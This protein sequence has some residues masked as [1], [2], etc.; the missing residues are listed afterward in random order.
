MIRN[1]LATLQ[2]MFEYHVKQHPHQ[3]AVVFDNQTITYEQLNQKANQLACYLQTIGVSTETQIALCMDRSIDLFIVILGILKAGAAYVPLDASYPD[4][5]LLLILNE[6]KTSL[7]IT[8]SDYSDKFAH[9]SG[10]ILLTGANAPWL[11]H[12]TSLLPKA[13]L[14]HHLAYV[15]YTSGSTGKPKGV[16]VEHGGVVAYATWFAE[17][18]G[19]KTGDWIDFSSN[20]AFDFAL[21][22]SIIP[23]VL[24]ATV[25]ICDDIIKKDPVQYLEYL[26]ASKVTFIKLTPSYF[27]VLLH[28][29]KLKPMSL[30]SVQ[31][32]ML[33]G[34]TLSPVECQAWLTLYP[35]HILFNE[36]GPTETS[37]AVCLYRIDSI[38][39]KNIGPNMPIG[40]LVPGSEA[41]ILDDKR[42][43]V[44]FGEIGELY[45][46]GRCL[47][48]G[49]LNNQALTNQYFIKHPFREDSNAR[50]YKTGDLCRWLDALNLECL[51]RID[52][53]IKIRGFRVEPAEIEECLIK[54]PALKAAVVVAINGHHNEKVLAA[55]YILNSESKPVMVKALRDYLKRYLPDFMIPVYFMSMSSFPLNANEKL[56]R[57]ALPVPILSSSKEYLAPETDMEKTLANIWSEELGVDSIGLKDNFFDAG[58]HSLSVARIVSTINHD[59]ARMISLQEFYQHPTVEELA[60]LLDTKQMLIREPLSNHS[61][62]EQKAMLPL[63]DFQL[64]LWLSNTFAPQAN[65]LNIG[66]RK[67]VQG[68]IDI[69]RLNHAFAFVIEKHEVLSW[70]ILSWGPAQ[71]LRKPIYD[72]IQADDLS[73]MTDE[74]ANDSLDQSFRELMTAYAWPK[75]RPLVAIRLFYLSDNVTEL[76]LCLPHIMADNISPEILLSD[77]SYFY[78]SEASS[79]TT[80]ELAWRDYLLKEQMYTDHFLDR[81]IIFWENY[82]RDA[83]LI[84]FSKDC[85]IADMKRHNMAYSTYLPVP[86]EALD[87]LQSFCVAHHFSMSDGLTAAVLIALHRCDQLRSNLPVCVARVKSTRD[88]AAYDNSIGCFLNLELIKLLVDET[89]NLASVGKQ[90]F[91]A[92][93]TTSAWQ[94]CST[95]VKLGNIGVFNQPKNKLKNWLARSLIWVYSRAFYFLRINQKIMNHCLRLNTAKEN[96]FLMVLNIHPHFLQPDRSDALLFGQPSQTIKK[97]NH[98]LLEVDNVLDICFMRQPDNQPY[99][100]VS[101]NLNPKFRQILGREILNSMA[102]YS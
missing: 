2:A 22:T 25:V 48:R 78:L 90:A 9:Y 94:R 70:H 4:E 38:N 72:N 47:A 55:Y 46:G 37:V 98:D 60:K 71:Y 92:V 63:G 54:H 32:I 29:I 68:H 40:V 80:K 67:R 100:V 21:T 93:M 16:M 13:A 102:C 27:K 49:Y 50:L 17:Y 64:T 83:S 81:D 58:G 11:N 28:Q 34:E 84:S 77:L 61:M 59:L 26:V 23:L 57:F 65:K 76:H 101:A 45:L 69:Q 35:N 89:S 43:P 20:H 85:V 86:I 10:C 44:A 8:T 87:A 7:L 39:S 95:L 19:I 79:N 6:G 53:Q 56:D 33:A 52:H 99:L 31:K 62:V 1:S 97:D 91:E 36:Y 88:N 82:L 42:Q 30:D 66:V 18:C 5:R 41:F 51:G 24:G 15:I 3:T 74:D 12:D 73:F 75:H 14:A 96:H